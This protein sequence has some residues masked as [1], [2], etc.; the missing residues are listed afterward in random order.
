VQFIQGDALSLPLPDESCQV[1][2]V[3][4]GIR[5]VDNPLA[6]LREMKRVLS[7][8]GRA[9]VLEFG[10]PAIPGFAALYRLYSLIVLP[11]IGGLLTGNGKAYRYLERTSREFP[12]GEKF[13]SLM[14]TAGFNDLRAKSLFGG[15]AYIYTGTAR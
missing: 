9:G 5:N 15:I 7:R 14:Q 6:C 4:F 1:A 12:A 3:A 10:Q 13:L 11:L 8:G 2:T